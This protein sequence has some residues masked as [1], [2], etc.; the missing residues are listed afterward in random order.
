MQCKKCG[1]EIKEGYLF[2]HNCGEEVR[3]VPDY[4]PEMEELEIH[5]S[6]RKKKEPE[7]IE[8]EPEQPEKTEKIPIYKTIRWN[9]A[10][11]VLLLLAGLLAFVIAYGSVLKNQSPEVMQEAEKPVQE[12]E[13]KTPVR[14]PQ[15]GLPGGEYGYYISVELTAED[16]QTIHYTTDGS[17]PDENAP[18]YHEPIELAEGL[19]VIRAV[20]LSED[21]HF[22]DIS[23]ETYIV[24]F[25]GPDDPVITPET[26]DYIGEVYVNIIVPEGCTAYYTLDGTDPTESS[27][28]Y[29][30]EFLM[31]EGTT[32]V[33]AVLVGENGAFSGVS[34]VLY[35][36]V[37]EETLAQ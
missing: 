28:I 34:S 13:D 35:H 19:T 23:E 31:P 36:R 30:G 3:I 26:G 27:E 5:L 16:G 2:C 11:P 9:Y 29:S 14:M 17:A 6:D 1:T 24:E 22:S 20:A 7:K 18:V 8:K 25:G 21:G 32:T 37:P 12:P 33:R 10:L 15:F 4:E